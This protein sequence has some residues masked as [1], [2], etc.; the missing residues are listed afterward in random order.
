MESFHI[1]AIDHVVL[2]TKRVDAMIEFY[3]DKLG[4]NVE[5]T[6]EKEGLIQL[7]AG[8]ALIDLVDV[9]GMLGKRGGKP[10]EETGHNMDHFCL[11]ISPIEPEALFTYLKSKDLRLDEMQTRYG[12]TG[13]GLSVYLNDPDGNTVEL[14]PSK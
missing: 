14:K 10:P 4:C 8:H 5:R 13:F 12:A 7:R 3:C 9:E 11:L 6:L 2:R 1:L